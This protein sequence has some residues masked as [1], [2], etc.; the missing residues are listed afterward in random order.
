MEQIEKT[1]TDTNNT[2]ATK[3]FF[4]EVDVNNLPDIKFIDSHVHMINYPDPSK[5][6][7]ILENA[8]K[9]GLT[10][11]IENAIH[12]KSFGAVEELY[13]MNKEII[14]PSFGLHPWYL[15]EATEN[16]QKNLEDFLFK[17][18][19]AF[20]GEIGLDHKIE[21]DRKLQKDMFLKQLEIAKVF[22]RPTSV[23]CVRAHGEMLKIQK[24]VYG[25]NNDESYIQKIIMHSYSGS[26]EIAHSMLKLKTAEVYFS[27]STTTSEKGFEIIKS[28]P[29]DRI[30][31]ET[32]SP[33]QYN[34]IYNPTDFSE[35]Q[36]K[37]EL[38]ND[39][40]YVRNLLNRV[41]KLFGNDNKIMNTIWQNS[42]RIIKFL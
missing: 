6:K 18:P 7:N 8:H 4:D 23:H 35:D 39:P 30:I 1:N 2:L 21:L 19:N 26:K 5:V 40:A 33:H 14:V 17:Y 12:E 41:W 32:D 28:Q 11:V 9:E 36:N 37:K 24:K 13:L 25:K 29:E 42:L 27:F 10:H 20:V 34:S 38:I 22:Q 16:W 15:E 31:L 3:Y